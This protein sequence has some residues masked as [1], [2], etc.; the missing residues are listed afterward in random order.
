MKELPWCTR[1]K[2][3][4]SKRVRRACLIGDYIANCMLKQDMEQHNAIDHVS[5]K[6][7]IAANARAVG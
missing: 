7:N 3:A 1:L 6:S 5:K 2:K 4:E